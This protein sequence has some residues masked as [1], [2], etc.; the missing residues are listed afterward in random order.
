[1]AVESYE[2]ITARLQ[3]QQAQAPTAASDF[4]NYVQTLMLNPNPQGNMMTDAEA[5]RAD[6]FR[7]QNAI[8]ANLDA[9]L[10]KKQMEEEAARAAAAG[11]GMGMMTGGS[12]GDSIGLTEDQ[13]AFLDAEAAIPGARDA[14]MGKINS[15]LSLVA[16]GIVPGLPSLSISQMGLEAYN[17]MMQGHGRTV[18]G[19]TTGY[20]GQ[21][22]NMPSRQPGQPAPVVTGAQVQ[23]AITEAKAYNSR[24]S[25]VDS[26]VG[27]GAAP[28]T[29]EEAGYSGDFM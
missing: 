22:S 12:P 14:R 23:D 24:F 20:K 27:V 2:Q 25:P 29:A 17:D 10:K 9:A 4:A 6:P 19:D 1:M 18:A 13:I 26:G 3:G 8:N 15:M 7:R 11:G 21:T 16:Q 28:S 5:Y